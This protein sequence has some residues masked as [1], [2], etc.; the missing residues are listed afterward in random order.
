MHRRRHRIY[1]KYYPGGDLETAL[2]W[3]PSLGLATVRNNPLS[4]G[5]VWH[6]FESLIS[7]VRTLQKG[8]HE[9]DEPHWK[10]ITHLDIAMRNIFIE[11]PRNDRHPVSTYLSYSSCTG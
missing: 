6:V 2:G 10:P 8:N 11:E 9:T 4:E 5:F 7:A 3:E 1:L